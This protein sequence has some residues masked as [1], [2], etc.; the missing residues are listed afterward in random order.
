MGLP[1][2]E[3]GAGVAT[4]PVADEGRE[5]T[6]EPTAMNEPHSAQNMRSGGFRAS[7]SQQVTDSEVGAWSHEASG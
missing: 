4:V 6:L 1:E 3:A 7:Q 5:N 2:G